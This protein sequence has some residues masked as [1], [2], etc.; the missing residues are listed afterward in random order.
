ME[1]Q[2]S[3]VGPSSAIVGELPS[4]PCNVTNLNPPNFPSENDETHSN[5]GE[6]YFVDNETWAI[7]FRLARLD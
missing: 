6:L 1:R 2:G 5:D 3:R 7:L 4:I